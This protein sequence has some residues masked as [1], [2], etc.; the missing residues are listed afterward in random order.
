V[1]FKLTKA[2]AVLHRRNNGELAGELVVVCLSAS[3][4]LAGESVVFCLLARGESAGDEPKP[5][6]ISVVFGV[7][8]RDVPCA[9]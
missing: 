7:E 1:Y 2:V 3:R 8:V 9:L 6:F 5:R 4:E